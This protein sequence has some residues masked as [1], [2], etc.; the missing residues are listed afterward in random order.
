MD[1]LSGNKLL[2]HLDRVLDDR[3][4][5]TADIFLTNYCNNRCPYCTY[6]RWELDKGA[7]AM[8]YADFVTYAKRLLD[9]GVKGFILTGGGEP[10][11]NPDFQRITHWLEEHGIAYGVNTNF[12]IIQ[13]CRPDYLKVSLDGWDEDSYQAKRGVRK[14]DQVRDNIITYAHWRDQH[15]AKTAI[16]IQMVVQHPEEVMAFYC[17]NRDLPV[18][19]LSFRPVESTRGGYYHDAL[20][21]TEAHTIQSIIRSIMEEDRRVV[22]NFKWELLDCV[23]QRCDAHWSQLAIN[24]RGEVM[25]CCHKPYE[26]IGHIMDGDIM[27]RHSAYLTDMCRC[28]VPC[29]LTAPNQLMREVDRDIG[30]PNFL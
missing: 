2:H 20:N 22:K 1:N 26:L 16:G 4:P 25:Y 10:T 3:R 9:L 27:E 29:R 18:D 19:Y 7:R 13:Y 17:A 28:D 23:P 30:H 5:I 12:N 11:L 15:R 14:Y 8:A 6:R 24:E 21:L